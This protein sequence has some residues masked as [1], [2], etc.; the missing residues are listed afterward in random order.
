MFLLN[1][2]LNFKYKV[3]R[4]TRRN[5]TSYPHLT[6]D[7]FANISDYAIKAKEDL[8]GS[9]NIRQIEEAG[10]LFC[11]SE[12]LTDLFENH[13]RLIKAKVIF[14]GNSDFEFLY[15]LKSIPDSVS[16][17]YLQNSYISDSVRIFTLPIGIE[18]FKL[19]V[20]GSPHLMQPI[21]SAQEKIHA[22]LFGPFGA[23]HR[24]RANIVETF[25]KV[26]GPWKVSIERMSPKKYS[27]MSSKFKY[28]ASVRGNGADTHRLWEVLYRGAFPIVL[29]DKWSESLRYLDLPLVYVNEWTPASVKSALEKNLEDF[30]PR[31]LESLWMPYW[32]KRIQ[33][34]L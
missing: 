20:N 2:F 7:A 3:F 27:S 18:N 11:K 8:F 34:A 24:V 17:I 10:V 29:S 32:E 30:D 26:V 12:L 21:T 13:F 14:C 1:K 23:T 25:S 22:V 6:G 33:S 15:P 19:G 5:R 28:V 4:F 31:N 16:Q 9:H